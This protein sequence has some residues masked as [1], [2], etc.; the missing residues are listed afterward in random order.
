MKRGDW[1][2]LSFSDS[3]KSPARKQ[4]AL[5]VKVLSDARAKSRA[6]EREYLA[7]EFDPWQ[8]KPKSSHLGEAVAA[9]LATRRNL[10][11]QTQAKYRSV[12]GLLA[13][14]AGAAC[15]V[16]AL[17]V[18]IVQDF[19]DS[20]PKAA[21]TKRTYRTTLSPFFNW[22]L[23]RGDIQQT[24]SGQHCRDTRRDRGAGV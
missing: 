5:N 18:G 10:R 20:T 17:S 21:I 13:A 12:L 23:E 22:L 2:H 11:G 4:V 3:S 7:G 19:L 9:F 15:P 16:S 1:Y 24:P 6:L 8:T 14:F